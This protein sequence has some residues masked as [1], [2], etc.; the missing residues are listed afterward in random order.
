M[1]DT[2]KERMSH[3]H[4]VANKYIIS[5]PAPASIKYDFIFRVGCRAL[6]AI[7]AVPEIG[8]AESA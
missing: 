2:D 5:G 1:K 3:R 7:G 4:R 6:D 8:A